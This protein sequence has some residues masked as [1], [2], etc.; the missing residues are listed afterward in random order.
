MKKLKFYLVP[1]LAIVMVA[2]SFTSCDKDEAGVFTPDQKIYKIYVEEMG[3]P[4]TLQQEWI[5][6]GKLLDSII[7]Y[8]AN[9]RDE[10]E[11]FIYEDN[12][13]VKV[14]DSYDYYS[15]YTY[16]DKYYSKIEYFNPAGTLLADLTFTYLDEKVSNMVYTTYVTTKHVY[17]MLERGIL[18]KMLPKAAMEQF[19]K[20]AVSQENVSKA[21]INTAITYNGDNIASYTMGEYTLNYSGYDTKF[22][23]FYKFFPFET[24]SED[25][26][27]EVFSLNNPGALSTV[28]GSIS[29]PTTYLYT[30]E[31][32]YPTEVVMTTSMGPVNVSTTTTIEYK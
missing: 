19:I 15:T 3:S 22:N 13:L 29:V 16:N 14:V 25:R 6:D 20:K 4:K 2:I 9:V 18:G 21:V 10:F 7:Y 24:I 26:K 17:T 23:P 8:E 32:D 27:P 11:D 1:F 28:L 12:R 31:G 30:Y 5:W